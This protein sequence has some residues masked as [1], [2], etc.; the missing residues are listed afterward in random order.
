[1][2]KPVPNG[3]AGCWGMGTRP[4]RPAGCC[5]IGTKPP[6]PPKLPWDWGA[7]K[8]MVGTEGRE[9]ENAGA[10]NGLG[11]LRCK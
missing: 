3:V 5:G 9:G 4:V 11:M 10:E 7:P 8:G 2:P 6:R 1:M